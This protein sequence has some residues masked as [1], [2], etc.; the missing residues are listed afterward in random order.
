[1]AHERHVDLSV[2]LVAILG[3][4]IAVNILG[5]S[6]FLR[7][8]L[9]RDGQYTL[10]PASRTT[11]RNLKDPVIVRAYFTSDLPPPYSSNRR[12]V[13]DLL[14][15]YYS[16]SNGN[17]RYE[18][19]DPI[20]S[21]TQE[22]KEKKKETKRDIF[23][24][25]VREATSVEQELQDVG[26]PPVQVRVNEDDKLEVKR[27]YMGIA[28]K[29]G[30]NTE[31]IPVVRS[32]EGLEYDITSLVRKISRERTPKVAFVS[33]LDNEEFQKNFGRFYGVLS[34]IYD[35]TTL[36]L[37][38]TP[39]I[40]DDI[41][42]LVVLS[43]KTPFSSE[44][45]QTLDAFVMSGRSV[46]FFVDAVKPDLQTMQAEEV[47]SGLG[48]L[49][50][51]YGVQTQ[52]GLVL[53]GVCATIN[54]AQRRGFM[55][56]TQPVPYPFMPLPEALDP[57]HPLTRGLAQVSFPFVSPLELNLSKDS[58]VKGEVLVYSSSKSFVHYP[59]YNLD[60]FH[61]W[62]ESELSEKG[63]KALVVTLSGPLPSHTGISPEP[64]SEDNV[65]QAEVATNAR[66]AVI[67]GSSIANDQFQQSKTNQAFLLN[68]TDWLL[69]DEDLLA[70]RAKG[71]AAAPLGG[72]DENGEPQELGDGTRKTV[73]YANVVG[74][75]IFFVAFGLVR[76]RMREN[77]RSR[78]S[79]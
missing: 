55:T 5:I 6:L 56:I 61:Q 67:G 17:F 7:A 18:L 48:K 36:D 46:A 69:L 27:A 19:I 79:V 2:R 39:N 71:L 65:S 50:E 75:P 4:L 76:W 78:V 15:E 37:T 42:A 38:T 31:A 54:I 40:A 73:K 12:Y 57:N 30:E 47:D 3:I 14:E 63:R 22:D 68:L 62:Q 13:Q 77:R 10:S 35:V 43:P 25:P 9:T 24:R 66:V 70:I 34:Q 74:L 52:K 72:V 53:D 11:V 8:D 49:L 26:I 29:Y 28:I 64:S 59:P 60:P 23:G 32:T 41:D 16:A 20:A 1:M 33:G 21:E 45:I 51:T 44:Q 58:N